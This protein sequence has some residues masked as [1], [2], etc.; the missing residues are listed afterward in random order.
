M[1]DPRSHVRELAHRHLAA[2]DPTGWFEPL[3]TEASRGDATVPWADMRA[4]PHLLNWLKQNQVATPSTALVVGC[5]LGDDA[6]HLASLG[7][8]TTAFDISPTA[9][10]WC[11]RRFPESSVTYQ[12]R[13]LLAAPPEWSRAFDFIF[14]AYTLQALPESVRRNAIESIAAFV[15]PGGRL[16]VVCRG[17]EP[18]DPPGD[19]P[20]PL[21]RA[22]L[23]IFEQSGLSVQ[24][25]DDFTDEEEPD[26]RRFRVVYRGE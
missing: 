26:V 3:Y 12:A 20:W 23:E 15:A 11:R 5:G 16:L 10:Q 4:N 25:F 2:G 17:R 21:T 6:E 24:S 22:E 1:S 8:R 7:L 14:E 9:I 18:S 19:L 13:D